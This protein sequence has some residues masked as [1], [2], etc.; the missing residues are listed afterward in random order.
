MAL[1]QQQVVEQ[2][3]LML[4]WRRTDAVRLNMLHSYIHGRQPFLWLPEVAPVE[5][6]RIAEMSRVNVLGLVVDAV[7]QSMY[8]DGYRSPQ[9]EGEAPA[10]DIWQRNK[11]DARQLGVHRAA[12]GYGVAYTVV[13]PGDPVAVIRGISPRDMT[14][15]YGEDDDWPVWALERRRSDTVGKTLYRLFDDQMAYWVSVDAPTVP[16][17]LL[18]RYPWDRWDTAELSSGVQY[19]ST[20]EHGLGVVPVVRYLAKSDLDDEVTSEC[21]DLMAIQDQ[22]NLTTFGLLVVQHYGAFPQKWIAGWAAENA[23][24]EVAVAANKILTFEDPETKL[25]EFTAASLTG[26]IESRRD[27]LRNLAAISQTP[28]HALRGELVNLSAEALAA[29]EQA[30]RRKITERETMFG[31]AWEQTLA[32]AGSIAGMEVDP[33]AEVRWKDTEARAFA[34]TVD[35]LGKMAQMLNIPVQELWERVPGV[36]QQDVERW[37]AAAAEGDAFANLTNMLD[38]QAGSIDMGQPVAAPAPFNG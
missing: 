30:E 18:Y 27:S 37:K 1:S 29:A 11:L 19:I 32:L 24:D 12:L 4:S 14:T 16:T 10:W 33:A 3:R 35:A 7:A 34:A 25:G 8:V 5:V 20:E 31:E 28:A 9:A 21:D 15:V 17:G 2:V 22:I 13:L 23:E 36:T 6:R 26:Y 38:R